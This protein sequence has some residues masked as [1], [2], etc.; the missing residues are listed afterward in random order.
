MSTNP[1]SPIPTTASTSPTPPAT[2]LTDTFTQPFVY[3]LAPFELG[4]NFVDKVLATRN[5]TAITFE[6]L[7]ATPSIPIIQPHVVDRITVRILHGSDMPFSLPNKSWI[8]ERASDVADLRARLEVL[9]TTVSNF[10]ATR[11]H[12]KRKD[13]EDRT[14]AVRYNKGWVNVVA[15]K[16]LGNPFLECVPMQMNAGEDTSKRAKIVRIILCSPSSADQIR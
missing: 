1:N 4:Q 14:L 15:Q 8:V 11:T 3:I 13:S 6:L 12:P 9:N 2:P 5:E 10:K 16:G 7:C